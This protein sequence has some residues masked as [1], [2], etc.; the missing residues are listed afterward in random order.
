MPKRVPMGERVRMRRRLAGLNQSELSQ[1]AGVSRLTIR[2]IERGETTDPNL[3]T[4][5]K[6]AR[7]CGCSVKDLLPD[8][9]PALAF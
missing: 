3:S 1:K 9:E 6:I 8:S 5:E 7:A 2:L 4:L